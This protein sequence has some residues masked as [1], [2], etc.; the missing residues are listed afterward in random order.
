MVC[1]GACGVRGCMWCVRVH[2][3]GGLS[4]LVSAMGDDYTSTLYKVGV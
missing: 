2:V 3:V 1:E 4:G